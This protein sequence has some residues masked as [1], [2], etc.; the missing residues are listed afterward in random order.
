[1]SGRCPKNFLML[2]VEHKTIRWNPYTQEWFC[3]VCGR[4]SDHTSEEDAR[5]ELELY[6]CQLPARDAKMKP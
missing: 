6:E 4:T 2:G 1:M 5:H 3:T